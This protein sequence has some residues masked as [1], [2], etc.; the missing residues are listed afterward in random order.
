MNITKNI[1]FS[2]FI[3]YS[4]FFNTS[5]STEVN[6]LTGSEFRDCSD[7]PQMVVIPPGKFSMGSDRKEQ[8]RDNELRPEG[9]IRNISISK[10]F[11]VG[12]YEITYSEYERF[13]SQTGHE[14]I[15]SC[16]VWGSR[17]TDSRYNWMDPGL[18][19]KPKPDEPVVC[20]NWHDAKAYTSWLS[21]YTGKSYRLLTEAEWE[22]IAKSGS[23]ELWP[24]GSDAEE[25]CKYGNVYDETGVNERRSASKDNS[26]A[27]VAPCNDGYELVAPVGKFLPNKFGLYDTIGNVW[28]WTEDCSV[29]FYDTSNLDGSDFQVSGKCDK[30]SVRSGS[31]RSRLSRHRP[32]FRGRDPAEI[33]YFHFGLRIARDVN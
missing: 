13:V 31:W 25:I 16:S 5:Q 26:G 33:A 22:Y 17:T 32:S 9:P 15:N 10:Y 28:E 6:M 12:K 21:N 27:Q 4:F 29:K 23:S 20:I 7:C 18:G 8:M 19:Q 3:F 2:L 24:W 14:S 1:F 30:R 11:A